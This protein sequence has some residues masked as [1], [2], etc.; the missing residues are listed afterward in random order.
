MDY[1]FAIDLNSLNKSIILTIGERI[2]SWVRFGVM[3]GLQSTEPVQ[4]FSCPYCQSMFSHKGR[5]NRHIRY[6]M[7]LKSHECPCCDA[8][9]VERYNLKRHI[10]LRHS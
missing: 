6:H 1:Y 10:R 4:Q 3:Y 7:G 8:K 5:L 9:F 2:K